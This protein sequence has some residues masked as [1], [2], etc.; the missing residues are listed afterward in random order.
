MGV[1]C[2]TQWGRKKRLQ[3]KQRNMKET[4]H[5]EGIGVNEKVM[6]KHMLIKQY[7]RAWTGFSWLG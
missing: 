4:E 7:R 3:N 6:I 5:L 1:A 2:D